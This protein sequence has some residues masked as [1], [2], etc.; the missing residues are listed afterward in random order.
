VTE[1]PA[2][3]PVKNRTA[4]LPP[5]VTK[6]HLPPYADQNT[7]MNSTVEQL[8]RDYLRITDHDKSAAAALTLADVMQSARDDQSTQQSAALAERMLNLQEAACFLG[9]TAHCLRKIVNRSRRSHNGQSVRGPTIEFFQSSPKSTILFRREWLE[10]F[11]EKHHVRA[12]L[13]ASPAIRKPSKRNRRGDIDPTSQARQWA[14][15][16]AQ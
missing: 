15:M 2:I 5:P 8:F 10:Q 3:E 6:D 16:A 14:S 12:G 9:Y 1:P 13:P 7:P 4:E 11:I